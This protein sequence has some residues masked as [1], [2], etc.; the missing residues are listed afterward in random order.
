MTVWCPDSRSVESN[1][2]FLGAEVRP[3]AEERPEGFGGSSGR[4]AEG[5]ASRSRVGIEVRT[6]GRQIRAWRRRARSPGG[7]RPLAEVIGDDDVPG[8]QG[9]EDLFGRAPSMAPS[10]TPGAVTS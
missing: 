8:M 6:V 1:C 4:R 10:K 9:H 2:A 7:R 5:F 3:G